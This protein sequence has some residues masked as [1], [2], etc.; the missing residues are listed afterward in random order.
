[1][2][3]IHKLSTALN[4]CLEPVQLIKNIF[5]KNSNDLTCVHYLS[6]A[7]FSFTVMM[8]IQRTKLIF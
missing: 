4:P 1:M 6:Y 3:I 2:E 7:S 5:F 8:P